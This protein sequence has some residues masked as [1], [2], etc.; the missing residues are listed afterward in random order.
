MGF[1][2]H[3]YFCSL[4]ILL[5]ANLTAK[6]GDFGFAMDMPEHRSGRTLVS[7]L[8][9]ARSDGYFAPELIGRRI[10]PKSDVY[11]FGVV[12]IVVFA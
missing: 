7:A 5:D 12:S 3:L 8:M 6:L 4:N 2:Y 1:I 9:I 10:S 11:S